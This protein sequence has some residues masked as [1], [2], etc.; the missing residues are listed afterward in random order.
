MPAES[1]RNNNVIAFGEFLL[2]LQSNAGKRFLQTD[3]YTAYYAGAEANVC[4]LLSRLGINTAYVTRVPD[5]DVAQAG[6]MQLRAQGVSVDHI[7]YGG[8]KL[9]VYFTE[10]GNAVRPSRVIYDRAGTSYA[11]LQPGMI[12]W[13]S[14]FQQ[15]GCFHWSG[16]A[17][18]VSASA[19]DVCKEALHAAMDAG[20]TIS[21]DFNYRSSLWTYGKHP[22]VV[23][24]ELL[25]YSEITVAD[26]DAAS[27]YFGIDIPVTLPQEQKFE[28]VYSKLKQRMPRLKTLGMSFRSVRNGQLWYNAALAH[29]DE[30]FFAE[31]FPLTVV[32]DQIGAGDAFTAGVLYGQLN[33]LSPQYT[34]DFAVACGMIK[35]SIPGDWALV[36]LEEITELMKN[37]PSGRIIR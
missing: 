31:G 24:P 19:A 29:N 20:I 2:R 30:L 17:A 25:Q 12:N 14:L 34:I 32:T 21:S 23:M 1:R 7:L 5:N 27:I 8:D 11:S 18:A 10:A 6:I 36:D 16:I 15:Y 13:S 4:V 35:Q 37:G 26:L 9:G 33:K 22:S 3:G 28:L